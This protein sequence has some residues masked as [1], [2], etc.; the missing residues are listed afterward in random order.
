IADRMITCRGIISGKL[1]MSAAILPQ[2]HPL[3]IAD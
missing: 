3:P 1:L 2:L